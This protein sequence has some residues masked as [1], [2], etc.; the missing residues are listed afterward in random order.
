MLADCYKDG[1]G[2]EKDEVKA[3]EYF[4]K[5]ADMGVE[6]AINRLKDMGIAYTPCPAKQEQQLQQEEEEVRV[7]LGGKEEKE[8]RKESQYAG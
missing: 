2:V 7:R 3:I 8:K 1:A 6:R 5:A 4:K